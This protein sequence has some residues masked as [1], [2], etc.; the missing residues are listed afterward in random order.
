[1]KDLRNP[2]F[3]AIFLATYNGELY[4]KEQLDSILSQVGV[5]VTIYVRDDGSVDSTISILQSYAEKYKNINILNNDIRAGAAAQNFIEIIKNV[6]IQKYQYVS[7]S[8]QDDIW[9]PNKISKAIDKMNITMSD[10]YSSN[11]TCFDSRIDKEWQLKKDELPT[12]FDYLFQGG[13]AGC[14][15]V[16]S[17]QLIRK[18]QERIRVNSSFC[19][20]VVSHDWLIYAI[21]RSYDY[22]WYYDS[23]SYIKYRQHENNVQGS[24]SGMS[25]YVSRFKRLKSGWYRNAIIS[26]YPFLLK[27][28]EEARIYKQISRFSLLD[29]FSLIVNFTKFRR[30]KWEAI[31]LAFIL[32]LGKM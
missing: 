22:K 31:M 11:L 5:S 13:S 7:F 21:A 6:D 15:Y 1:M 14:T 9:I 16:I 29:R 18:I 2:P 27:K 24:L 20:Q 10:G 23:S 26:L 4:L 19:N 25:G 28:P 32:I 17:N 8:D 3:V 30:N 12:K